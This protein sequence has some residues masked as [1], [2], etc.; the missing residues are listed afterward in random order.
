MTKEEEQHTWVQLGPSSTTKPNGHSK[1]V[2][3]LPRSSPS[4]PTNV[5]PS[6]EQKQMTRWRRMSDTRL[7]PVDGTTGD[8]NGTLQQI[9]VSPR[10]LL[11]PRAIRGPQHRHP[12]VVANRHEEEVFVEGGGGE[13]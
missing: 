13:G 2:G 9:R 3:P 10:Q 5:S 11:H 6:M 1:S 4:E 7:P 8:T 12:I